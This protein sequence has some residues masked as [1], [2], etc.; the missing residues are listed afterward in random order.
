ML[1]DVVGAS[2]SLPSYWGCCRWQIGPTISQQIPSSSTCWFHLLSR[3]I[4]RKASE[5]RVGFIYHPIP[6]DGAIH[7]S[8]GIHH[9]INPDLAL[10]ATCYPFILINS[11][12]LMMETAVD[13]FSSFIFTLNISQ[14]VSPTPTVVLYPGQ[15]VFRSR[16]QQKRIV[17]RFGRPLA[18]TSH[19]HMGYKI[20]PPGMI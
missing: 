20:G 13:N 1:Y 4:V 2:F 12:N 7:V 6:I 17:M 8:R 15:G 14:V 5:K 19:P 16:A 9:P 3:R 10:L 11:S 18:P